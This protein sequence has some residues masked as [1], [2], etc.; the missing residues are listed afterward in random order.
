VN[1]GPRGNGRRRNRRRRGGPGRPDGAAQEAARERFR[2][3]RGYKPPEA[4][5]RPSQAPELEASARLD[6]AAPAP[7]PRERAPR[8]S[9][10]AAPAIAWGDDAD[11]PT[12]E[13]RLAADLPAAEVGPE[14]GDA[15]PGLAGAPALVDAI[16]VRFRGSGKRYV[17][18]AADRDYAIGEEVVVE[19]E[20]GGAAIGVV[21]GPAARRPAPFS[22][23]RRVL[24]RPDADDRRGVER[25][26]ARAAEVRLTARAIA[27]DLGMPIKVFR[28]ELN[29][30]GNKAT[31]YFSSEDKV[32]FRQLLRELGARTRLRI[33]L[34]QTG[35]RDEAKLIGGIGSCGL[36]LCCSTWLPSF[37]PVSIKNAKDQG[38]VLNP[39][40]VSGQC[41][42]L[43]CCLVYEQATYA[44][45]R[46]G[47]P[48][49]GKRV[50]T[51]DGEG[52]VVEVDVLRQRI[53]VSLVHGELKVYAADAV[54]AMF[55][56]Q[57]APRP[58]PES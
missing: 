57:A 16:E 20:H 39:T 34:R 8:D 38:L 24:R 5:E 52:R 26:A 47:L 15:G 17:Y 29:L 51:S 30:A 22:P 48:R 27:R 18:D 13:I 11:A 33:E 54:T 10:D 46:K 25:N 7:L 6:A 55:P 32:D 14:R 3:E 42:R 12:P 23:V 45:L 36:E 44:E 21:A 41:G 35:V 56:S 4:P 9:L 37:A 43:K 1:D 19:A 49:V 50:V 2:A 58:E 53:R 28:A 40:K 31:I